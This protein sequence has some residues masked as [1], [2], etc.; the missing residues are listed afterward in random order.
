MV[1]DRNGIFQNWKRPELD[2]PEKDRFHMPE[3][4]YSLGKEIKIKKDKQGLREDDR[5]GHPV[6]LTVHRNGKRGG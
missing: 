1:N 3:M 2:L 6:I 5:W 4:E